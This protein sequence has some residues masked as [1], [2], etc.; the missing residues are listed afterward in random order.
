MKLLA[1]L[2]NVSRFGAFAL[3]S[4]AV[5]MAQRT[6][7]LSVTNNQITGTGGA[8]VVLTSQ[9]NEN[10]LGFSVTF[11][12][13]VLRFDTT[14][15]GTDLGGATLNVN[16]SQATSGKV[17]IA[18]ALPSGS[19]Y[20]TGNR[21]LVTLNFTVIASA[22]TSTS[23]GFGNTPVFQEI[24]D[25]AAN[26]LTATFTPVTITASPAPTAP[27][28]TNPT[29]VSV[30]A[31][32]MAMFSVTATGSPTPT[33]K[34]QKSTDSGTTWAD[35]ANGGRISGADTDMLHISGAVSSDIGSYRAIASNGVG[36]AATSAAATLTLTA[37]IADFT[38]TSG[39]GG[40]TVTINGAG[41]TGAT[42]VQ[43]NG[44]SATY[45]ATSNFQITAT[46][47]TFATTGPLSVTPATG[48]VLVATPA[49][50]VT[51]GPR[52][53]KMSQRAAALGNESAL[54]GTFKIEGAAKKVL[55]RAVSSTLTGTG[56]LADPFLSLYN[57]AGAQIAFNDNWGGNTTLSDAFTAVGASALA[58]DSKDSA[59]LAILNPGTYSA[60]VTGVGGTTGTALLEVYDTA[61]AH[62]MPYLSNRANVAAGT[63][64]TT[65]FQIGP[66]TGTKVVLIRAL[67]VGGGIGTAVAHPNPTITVKNVS[68][69]VLGTNDNWATSS[70]LTAA[71]AAVGA[72]PL[73]TNDAALLLTLT[74][75]IYS[76][77]TSGVGTT[78]GVVLTEVFAVDSFLDAE[79]DP[80]LLA[81]L[82][83][84]APALGAT[85]TL[86]ATFLAKPQPNFQWLKDGSPISGQTNATLTLTNVTSANSGAYAVSLSQPTR[87]VTVTSAVSNIGVAK[88]AQTIT[89]PSITPVAYAPGATVTLPL[90]A[91]SGLPIVYSSSNSSVA[92]VSGNTLTIAG[93]GTSDITA[94]QS[95]NA[96]FLPAATVTQ[97]LTVNKGNATVT[98]TA[99]TL[100]ATYDG[101][102]HAVTATT[103]PASLAFGITYVPVGGGTP[104]TTAPTN[105]GSYTVTATVND[106]LYQGSATGTLVIAKVNQTI[107]FGVLPTVTFG[108]P[109]LPLSA[110]GGAS[111]QPVTFTSGNTAVATISGNTVTIVGAGSA[112]ITANQAGDTNYNAA[113][114]VPQTLTVNK[115][116]ATVT[117]DANVFTYNG[118]IKGATATTSPTGLTLA[119]TYTGT[120]SSTTAPTNAGTYGVTATIVENNYQGSATGTVVIN[121]AD[122]TITFTL[123]SSFALDQSPVALLA[124]ASSGLPVAFAT[125]NPTNGGDATISGSTLTLVH[126][127]T[128]DITA[129]QVGNANFNAATSITRTLTISNQSQTLTF[130][131]TQLPTKTFGDAA[132]TITGNSNRKLLIT[133]V[134]SNPAVATVGTGTLN[135]TTGDTTATVTIVGA[136]TA[137][138]SAT[139]AGDSNTAAAPNIDRTL[140][141]NKA[142]ATITLGGLA[143][144]Y[145]GTPKAVTATTNPTG[146]GVAI[147]YTPTGGTASS[148]A[149]TNAGSYAVSAT[150][151][152]T[153]PPSS[154]YTGSATGTLVIAK[155]NQTISFDSFNS[156]KFVN[157]GAFSL[158]AT[159]TSGL[160]VT[161]TT[162]NPA[163]ASLSGNVAT[164]LTLGTTVI[165]AKQ[166]GDG[167]YNPATDVPQTLVVNPV[168]PVIVSTPPLTAT[169]VK[170][171][172]FLF[173]PITLNALSQP[174]TFSATGLPAGL[175]VNATSGNISGTPTVEGTFTVTLTV[176][177]A[178]GSDFK[179][180]N[181]TIN[182]PAP[183]ITSP[184]AASATAGS[185]FTYTA[186][187][188]P[189]TGVT[190]TA[191]TRPAWL[192]ISGATLSGTPTEAGTF[193]VLITATNV[194]GSVTLPLSIT[195]TL[196]PNA[197]AYSGTLNPSGTAGTAINF[198]PNF[199]TGT[200]TYAIT[201]TLPTG[202]SFSTTT[203]AITG[204]TQ[205][206][207]VF[208]ITISATRVGLTATANL[209]LTVNP[210]PAAPVVGFPS[211]G[212]VRTGAV[213]TA[214]TAIQ[215]TATPA[216]P[217]PTF[218]V[219]APDSSSNG[220]PP[221]IS[222][223]S[224]G[225]I[226]GTPTTQGSYVARI[227]VSNSAGGTGPAA[228]LRFTI[229][230]GANAPVI[231]S[232]PVVQGRVGVALS[233]ALTASPASPAATFGM[234][235]TVPG[236]S[237]A[238]STFSGT[239]T[240]SG[241]FTVFF[242][243]TNTDPAGGTGEA[244]D[245][246]F[247]IS[248]AL[249]V[250]VVNSNG[251]AAGQVGQP[252]SYVITATNSPT[253]FN[254]VG[255]P[256]GLSVNTAS[257]VISGVP[258]T[259]TTGPAPWISLLTATNGD[260]TSGPKLFSI[261]IAPAP[262]TPS[263][264]SASSATGRVGQAFSYNITATESPTS[265]V[266]ATL[267]PGLTVNPTTGAIGGTPLESGQFF[268][269]IAAA[270]TGGIGGYQTLVF[271]IAPALAAP[272]ITSAATATGQVGTAFTYQITTSGGTATSYA[273]TG[274]LPAG[275]T[276]NSSTGAISGSPTTP[277]PVT[278]TLT[279]TGDG[280]TSLPQSLVITINPALGVPAITSPNTAN[281]T[282]GANFSYTIT[283]TNMPASTPFPPGTSLDAINLPAGLAVNPATGVIQ[284]VPSVV[285]NTTASLFGRNAAGEGPARDLGITVQA[286]LTAPAVN[287]ATT[288][289]GQ[290]GTNFSYTIT[291]TN[292]PTS[293]EVLGA[294]AW[295]TINSV[296]GALAGSPTVPGTI[297]VRLV[298]SN[299]AGTSNPVNLTINIAALPGTPA[300]TS[301]RNALGQVT[302]AFSYQITATPTATS[303]SATGLPPGLAL[304]ASTGMINGTPT[305][306]GAYHPVVWGTLTGVG[307]GAPVQLTFTILPR[308]TLNAP[309]TPGN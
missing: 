235:G 181:L 148:T 112:V 162:S 175:T 10:A 140:T 6:V 260:G 85:V 274:T 305:V 11:D 52:F 290:V 218:T 57:N 244:A 54:V 203:G 178:S 304:N 132:F 280:G 80:A 241:S 180:I 282:V 113:T 165:T 269:A 127:G 59:I 89:F 109:A 77:E 67:G 39:S 237:L 104:T 284:G 92:T 225:L 230:P 200:T 141:V 42:A 86:A 118:S 252:F 279:A 82:H 210:A 83:D 35:L 106:T 76:V 209:N 72:M 186:T 71:T 277:G 250:P 240:T 101:N 286:P 309:G 213:G 271:T 214:I 51:E 234:T 134:S 70:A 233:Y 47:P 5:L 182:P 160:A 129:S 265:Y 275:L 208:P 114:P 206:V 199:G 243:G 66:S 62:R 18:L 28:I 43:F 55:I 88:S 46:V 254:A 65:S 74:N 117:L 205:Q 183:V 93:V 4:A 246:T 21:S 219:L 87:S 91:S 27:T 2:R 16:S 14:A 223:T 267:P 13:A 169:G 61:D 60:R 110:T 179:T 79:F 53:M 171:S 58:T 81:P 96:D 222:M 164:I 245:V 23:L 283:A 258:T 7:T 121:K 307:Q 103:N 217:T 156:P 131:A 187:A 231:T 38:P 99:S 78:A 242:A 263:I 166:A 29:N 64:N 142:A 120:S 191:P 251:T 157:A 133:F 98:L 15:N 155:A 253:S 146:L 143:Q 299:S 189:A 195:V 145:D 153:T 204:T 303:Y 285:G 207:G 291:A 248:P 259:A 107:S 154:N 221:G 202:L 130:A 190:F 25:A 24:S 147:T 56:L 194:T 306:S 297:T 270:N 294:P 8:T 185:A 172:T 220:L 84:Q 170:G 1:L 177:N 122:Q 273:V 19:A 257:G 111:G 247:N 151:T 264:T 167:N 236:L 272:V 266:A 211:P 95:G 268:A 228:T 289:S 123:A 149:P 176:T 125:S 20:A 188:T 287:S 37:G 168:P 124:T 227:T 34:W 300:I 63:T 298:A 50:T 261:T 174:A 161:F 36:T 26:T 192:N 48:S 94:S 196:P 3:A 136:G 308:A 45:T 198:T 115:A 116:S 135:T 281:A 97:T 302:T 226:S 90:N 108:D 232:A 40:T 105:A 9:G 216:T 238:G 255:L 30:P 201:G 212:N 229:N 278:V 128:I 301:T 12:P 288:A 73:G 17:G 296:N 197:P 292:S 69:T 150:I 31:G 22:S 119:F 68:G 193:S 137:T 152:G 100:S 159:A 173:G 126:T 44:L 144:T 138:I 293:F 41:F 256:G 224:A 276:L 215:L 249:T 262:A 75:G 239:P 163:V 295:M 102:Q 49:F 184:A 33:I 139:Q 158:N 32:Q